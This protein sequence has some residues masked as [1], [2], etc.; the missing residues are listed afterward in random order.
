[1]YIIHIVQNIQALIILYNIINS[2]QCAFFESNM[3]TTVYTHTIQERYVIVKL[4]NV[5]IIYAVCEKSIETLIFYSL[6]F[7]FFF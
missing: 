3:M 6:K 4:L 1:M 7:L 2:K 5:L